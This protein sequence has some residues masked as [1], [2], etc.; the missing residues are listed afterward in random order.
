V[1]EVTSIARNPAIAWHDELTPVAGAAAPPSL[2]P[3]TVT[4]SEVITRAS[5]GQETG[6]TVHIWYAYDP[7]AARRG[8]PAVTAPAGSGSGAA[9][10]D[11]ALRRLQARA[12]E[13]NTDACELAIC[14]CEIGSL[15]TDLITATGLAPADP[16]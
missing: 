3:F 16:R 9:D 5:A 10:R 8:Q 1:S 14:T 4:R 12:A 2:W 11:E 13:W 7:A 6:V 15:I